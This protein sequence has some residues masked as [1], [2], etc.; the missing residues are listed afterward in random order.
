[1]SDPR[2][3]LLLKVS[4]AVDAHARTLEELSDRILVLEQMERRRCEQRKFLQKE[5]AAMLASG[6]MLGFAKKLLFGNENGEAGTT[7][8]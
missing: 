1:V 5:A 6:D 7:E 8:V 4:E 3:E 2:D